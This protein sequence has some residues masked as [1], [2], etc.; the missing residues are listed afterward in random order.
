MPRRF[1][2]LPEHDR[3]PREMGWSDLPA[4]YWK[5]VLVAIVLGVVGGLLW[6][7]W[8]LFEIRVLR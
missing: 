7:A 1:S 5:A 3:E 6:M 8:R 4:L 2:K